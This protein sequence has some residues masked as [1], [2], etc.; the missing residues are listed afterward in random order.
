LEYSRVFDSANRVWLLRPTGERITE[1]VL[2]L[3]AVQHVENIV[4]M[5]QVAGRR[6][7]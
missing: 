6:D 2:G 1:Y 4:D 7:S 3:L 5:D